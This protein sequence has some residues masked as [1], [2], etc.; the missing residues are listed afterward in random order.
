MSLYYNDGRYELPKMNAINS[1][2]EL[3]EHREEIEEEKK[4]ESITEMMTPD[5]NK[6]RHNK[7]N[8]NLLGFNTGY[9]DPNFIKGG[10]VNRTRNRNRNRNRN[11]SKRNE[12]NKKKGLKKRSLKKKRIRK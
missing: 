2:K 5:P 7:M 10:K 12:S 1:P 9:K 4:N 6:Y 11:R 3:A 8:Q